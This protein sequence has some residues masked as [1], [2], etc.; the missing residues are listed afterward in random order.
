MALA[1]STIAM[2]GLAVS[3]GGAFMSYQQQRQAQSNASRAAREQERANGVTIAQ[4]AQQAAQ[5]R[6]Q[7]IR[8]ER[9][10]RA[11]ILQQS[12]NMGTA[13]SSGETGALGGMKTHL[14]SNLGFNQSAIMAGQQIS[15]FNQNAANF[16]QSAQ[17]AQGRAGMWGQVSGIGGN[18]FGQAGGWQ[19]L[20]GNNN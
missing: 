1:T 7:Q 14:G 13:N 17:T 11:S 6:R 8:E 15:G 16:M 9:I 5:E 20:F 3:A 19:T 18:I 4:Q 2:I 12:E 10:K